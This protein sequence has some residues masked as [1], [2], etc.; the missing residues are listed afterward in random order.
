MNPKKTNETARRVL[1]VDDDRDDL[2]ILVDAF[3]NLSEG[4]WQIEA[5]DSVGEALQISQQSKIQLVILAVNTPVLD[6]PLM[7]NSFSQSSFDQQQYKLKKVIMTATATDEKRAAALA[8]GADMFIE[9][10]LSPEGLKVAFAHISELAGWALPP[11][12][13]SGGHSVGLA[14]LIAQNIEEEE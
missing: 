11:D 8:A 10:P 1:I 3:R 5:V 7:L 4:R 14:D 12:F 13:E 6:V 2:A 9:K